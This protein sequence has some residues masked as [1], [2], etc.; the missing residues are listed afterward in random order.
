MGD[1]HHIYALFA[2]MY[3]TTNSVSI[4]TVLKEVLNNDR[5][6]AG[7][8]VNELNALDVSFTV[9]GFTAYRILCRWPRNDS[10]VS[11]LAH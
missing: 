9:L 1:E 8:I 5:E 11:V 3:S 2:A 7:D 10:V 4:S 6:D